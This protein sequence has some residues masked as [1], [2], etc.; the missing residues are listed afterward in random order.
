MV[1][2]TTPGVAEASVLAPTGTFDF[3]AINFKINSEI[4]IPDI[5]VSRQIYLKSRVN[6]SNVCSKTDN[7]L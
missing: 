2:T 1:L 7:I 3:N 4:T 5:V 6:W